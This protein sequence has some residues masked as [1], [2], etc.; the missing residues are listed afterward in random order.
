MS[1]QTSVRAVTEKDQAAWE[2]FQDQ[3]FVYTAGGTSG[4]TPYRFKRLWALGLLKSSGDCLFESCAPQSFALTGDCEHMSDF[5]T[6]GEIELDGGTRAIIR[7]GRYRHG[8]QLAI[9]LTDASTHEP[10]G[11]LSTN[12]AAY[13][14]KIAPDAFAVKSWSENTSLAAAMQASGL[15][16]DT[17]EHIPTGYVQAPVW[18]IKDP[19]LVPPMERARRRE[20]I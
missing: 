1:R 14:A 13:G 8:G 5:K 16:E 4:L 12:L 6:I 3:G 10:Y 15:F 2:S 9:T 17:G 7:A 20:R 11:V 18:R 19:A